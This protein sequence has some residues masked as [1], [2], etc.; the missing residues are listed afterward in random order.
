MKRTEAIKNYLSAYTHTDLADLYNYNMEVQVNVAPDDGSKITGTTKSGH[1]WH[2]YT[3]GI[4]TWKSFRIP[5]RAYSDPEYHDTDINFNMEAHVEGIGMTGWDWINKRSRWVAFDFD[6]IVDHA[7]GLS[8]EELEEVRKVAS[9]IPWVTVR[10]STSGKGLH[11]YV[12]LDLDIDIKTH[13]EHSAL[14]RAIL[15]KMSALTGFNFNAKVDVCG[16]NMWVWHRKMKGTPGLLILKSGTTLNEVPPNWQDHLHVV[17][18]RKRR[19][20]AFVEDSDSDPFEE[21]CA[22][23][24]QH[25]LE[26]S[27]RK[28]FDYLEQ[29]K[30]QW[31]WDQDRYLLVCHTY[32]LKKAYEELGWQGIFE[33]NATG[34]ERGVD[35]NCFCRPLPR[36]AW[37]IY[38][39]TP[40]IQEHQSWTQT[41]TGWTY[42]LVNKRPDVRTVAR[43]HGACELEKGGF[44]F[45]EAEVAVK[46][47]SDFGINFDLHPS[48]GTRSAQIRTNRQGRLVME[49]AAS[50]LDSPEK[51]P[52]GWYQDKKVWKKV[53]DTKIEMEDG[54][55]EMSNHDDWVRHIVSTEGVDQGWLIKT[56]NQWRQ[57]PL[58]H[59]EKYLRNLGI[60]GVSADKITGSCIMRPWTIVSEPFSPE[61]LGGRRWNRNSIQFR[62]TPCT[63]LDNLAYPHWQMIFDH[64]G[65]DLD[66]TIKN[67]TWCQNNNI[68]T[69]ADYLLLWVASVFKEPTQPL[70]YLFLWGKQNTGKSILHESLSLLV[71]GGIEEADKALTNPS[72]FNG[73][74]RNAIVCVIE[75]VNLQDS[76]AAYD[77]MKAWVTNPMIQIHSK[78][79][80]PYSIPNTTH[81]IQ[82]ANNHRYCPIFHDDTRITMIHVPTL[83]NPIPKR[84]FM[85][86]LEK[87]A[88][89][90]LAALL[91]TEIP[92]SN[93]RLNVPVIQTE[94]KAETQRYN[95]SS[96]YTFIDEKCHYVPG[97]MLEFSQFYDRFIEWVDV[98]EVSFWTKKRV[99][100]ELPP[101]IPKGKPHGSGYVHLGNLSWE[102]TSSRKPRLTSNRG[103]LI[104]QKE[105]VCS[106]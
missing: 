6:K 63:D 100:M 99:S 77:R 9:E 102:L 89:D 19:T 22:Q 23:S 31:W 60:K 104:P 68:L 52:Y 14:A 8:A 38:R 85:A 30:A 78:N 76:G 96:L 10:R 5:Y 20:K 73:E 92:P 13:T 15:G 101:T 42:C 74:L 83:K 35:H 90:F 39:F 106:T 97:E 17:S 51:L 1:S 81:W 41:P 54:S 64:I 3:D 86:K 56:D 58:K 98:D 65:S 21:L 67:T 53:F 61:Y 80:T 46:A 87:E 45:N 95:Q 48:F 71:T 12:F 103:R 33:T 44:Q 79:Q 25:E 94:A 57:E 84:D 72:G 32:D 50:D 105:D 4:Q 93:D 18:G 88:S 66:D 69:G 2:G 82:T 16:G 49:M 47:L 27:H 34:K 36:G 91:D 43:A 29:I 28:L 24:A 59:V 70:P 62:V 26:E 75:E 11:L 7:T 40:G 37:A 55:S